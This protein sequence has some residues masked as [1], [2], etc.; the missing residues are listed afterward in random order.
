MKNGDYQELS[1]LYSQQS[2]DF[3]GSNRV[4]IASNY[5]TLE[6]ND[7]LNLGDIIDYTVGT[8]KAF[9]GIVVE[10]HYR[11]TNGEMKY[12]EFSLYA[13]K[14]NGEWVYLHGNDANF[15]FKTEPE[16]IDEVNEQINNA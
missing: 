10:N 8:E 13:F 4:Q 14:E 5:R 12:Q 16:T 9:W 1:E 15:N 11:D 2:L 6:A 3:W 7:Q